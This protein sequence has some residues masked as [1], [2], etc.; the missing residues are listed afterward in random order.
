MGENSQQNSQLL[1]QLWESGDLV[2]DPSCADVTRANRAEPQFTHLLNG[3]M[4]ITHPNGLL[5]I[6]DNKW[7]WKTVTCSSYVMY[8]SHRPFVKGEAG[9]LW[10]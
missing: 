7:A 5:K 8:L 3:I 1:L 2:S 9:L 10:S 6:S 4:I